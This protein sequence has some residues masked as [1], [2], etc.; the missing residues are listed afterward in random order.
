MISND[1]RMHRI[2]WVVEFQL[3]VAETAR[4]EERERE[5]ERERTREHERL[6]TTCLACIN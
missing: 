1:F 6:I 5:G 4:K 2:M 3:E